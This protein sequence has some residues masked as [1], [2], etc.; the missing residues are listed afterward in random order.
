MLSFISLV[1]QCKVSSYFSGEDLMVSDTIMDITDEY[2]IVEY[3]DIIVHYF[4]RKLNYIMSH[5]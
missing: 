2:L 3:S 4:R 1:V 5:D